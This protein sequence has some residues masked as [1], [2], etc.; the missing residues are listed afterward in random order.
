[1][2]A[3]WEFP[4]PRSQHRKEIM[5][6]I[7]EVPSMLVEEIAI[8]NVIA[9]STTGKEADPDIPVLTDKRDEY[10]EGGSEW[11]NGLW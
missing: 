6:K 8:E 10:D 2:N 11:T 5:K 7:Y 1:M 3:A 9:L 4:L